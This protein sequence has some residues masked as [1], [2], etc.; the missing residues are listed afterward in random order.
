M[1]ARIKQ[2]SYQTW[3][4]TCTML[5]NFYGIPITC[6]CQH[7]R[8]NKAA[9]CD[10]FLGLYSRLP[11]GHQQETSGEAN[12]QLS[13][14]IT[15]QCG[16]SP[17]F[18]L[19]MHLP[20]GGLIQT[21]ISHPIGNVASVSCCFITHYQQLILSSKP[22]CTL[23]FLCWLLF[24]NPLRWFHPTGFQ[25]KIQEPEVSGWSGLCS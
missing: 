5:I 25:K 6:I 17:L 18:S 13:S 2:S 16:T 9:S 4:P 24:F 23:F 1:G 20:E 11:A 12:P 22:W 3:S 21:G 15:D 8:K 19:F 10:H 14:L 7:P